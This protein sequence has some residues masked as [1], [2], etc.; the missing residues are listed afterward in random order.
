MNLRDYLHIY[1]PSHP[2]LHTLHESL[3]ENV[4]ASRDGGRG[5]KQEYTQ[6]L[7]D[8][9]IAEGLRKVYICL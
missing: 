5:E 2:E 9:L 3:T 6:Y 1:L 4:E 8:D 7:P